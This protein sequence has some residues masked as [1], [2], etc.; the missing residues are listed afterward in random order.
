MR[1]FLKKLQT[2]RSVGGFAPELPHLPPAAEA[3]PPDPSVIIVVI[4]P[5]FSAKATAF[6]CPLTYTE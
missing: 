5:Y 1:I 3:L 6:S 2:R 4:C